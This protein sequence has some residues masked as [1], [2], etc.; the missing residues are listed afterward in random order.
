MTEIPRMKTRYREEIIPALQ[1]EFDIK[2]VMQV[3]GVVKV[4]VN[5]FLVGTPSI[6]ITGAPIGTLLCYAVIAFLNMI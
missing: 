5:W 6:N 4:V 1:S 3:P 2:N